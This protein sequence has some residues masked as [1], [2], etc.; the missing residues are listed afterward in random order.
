MYYSRHNYDQH[1]KL[2]GKL[3]S[4]ALISCREG[5][6]ARTIPSK[7]IFRNIELLFILLVVH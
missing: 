1:W 7:W 4:M 2:N 3:E 6:S 5:G